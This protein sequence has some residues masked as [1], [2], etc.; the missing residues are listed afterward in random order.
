MSNLK[1]IEKVLKGIKDDWRTTNSELFTLVKDS[2]EAITRVDE[3]IKKPFYLRET[4]WIALAPY[5]IV[6]LL[7]IVTMKNGGCLSIESLG[8][9][10]K[11]T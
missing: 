3:Y 9:V 2:T 1:D 11:C 8:S 6:L 7:G 5:L 4:F 10:G